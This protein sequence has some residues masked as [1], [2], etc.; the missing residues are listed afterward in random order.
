V[1]HAATWGTCNTPGDVP[2]PAASGILPFMN[3]VF[4]RHRRTLYS[5]LVF[6]VGAFKSCRTRKLTRV[7]WTSPWASYQAFSGMP[8]GHS[9]AATAGF[10]QL[11]P[12]VITRMRYIYGTTY[13]ILYAATPRLLRLSTAFSRP[14]PPA[15]IPLPW[16]LVRGKHTQC[17][18]SSTSLTFHAT[19]LRDSG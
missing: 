10:G 1:T 11:Q 13:W 15:T 18:V 17:S 9:G 3:V 5:T 14:L 12:F 16:W 19:R 8:S 7:S 2:T 6:R 4:L